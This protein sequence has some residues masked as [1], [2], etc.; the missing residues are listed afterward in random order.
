ML[1]LNVTKLFKTFQMEVLPPCP[2]QARAFN[3]ALYSQATG[4]N[5][6]HDI[7]YKT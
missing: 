6:M 2:Q 4:I 3:I 1:A 5:L 7:I